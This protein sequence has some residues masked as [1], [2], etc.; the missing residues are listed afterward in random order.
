MLLRPFRALLAAAALGALSPLPAPAAASETILIKGGTLLTVTKGTIE[1]GDLLIRDGRIAAIGRD[2][3][4]P[5]GAR[6]IDATGRYVLPGIVDTHSHMGVYPWPEVPANDDGNEMTDPVTPGLRAA[7]SLWAED[8]EF[9]LARAGGV[10]TVQV[11]PGS[12]NLIGGEGVTLKLRPNAD[13]GRMIFAGAP[14]SIKMAL[15][16]N[17]KRVYGER[18]KAP[19][20]RMGNMALFRDAF[21]R[22]RNYRAK[23]QAWR[24]SKEKER[25]AP[26]D[27]DL[28]LDVL[29]DVLDGKVLV[30]VHSYRKDEILMFLKIADEYGFKVA[31]FQHGLEAYKIAPELA[32]RDIA[33]AT[34]AQWWGY[35]VEAWDG[36][37]HNAALLARAGV[38]V[39]IHSDSGNLVQRLYTEA[40]V[41]ARY[42]LAEEDALKAITLNAATA[43]GVGD[44]IGSLEV[45]KDADIAIF[46]RHPLDAYTLVEKTLIDGQVVYER[47]AIP[48][49]AGLP[50][51][52]PLPRGPSAPPPSELVPATA[53]VNPDGL[54]AVVG[55]RLFTMTG[56]PIDNGTLVVEKG[57]IKEVGAGVRPPE[58]ATVIDARGAWVF[59]GFIESHTSLGLAEIDQVDA[60][61][62]DDE[63]TDPITPDLRALDAYYTE[64]EIIPVTRLHGVTAAFA[65]PGEGNVLAGRGDVVRLEGGSPDEVLV[66]AGAALVAN[67]GEPPKARYGPRHESPETRMGIAALVRGAFTK[68]R[69]YQAKWVDYERRLKEFGQPRPAG[70]DARSG[71]APERPTPP[72]RDLKMEALLPALRGEMPVLVRAH[73]VDD[74]MTAVR[75]ASEFN[76]KLILSHGTE[77]YKVADLLAARNIPVVVGPITTQPE[78][79]ETAGAL[80]DNAA[81]LN[82]AGVKIAIQMGET[83]N[84][85]MLPYE[86]ALAVAY[87][88][89]WDQA[90]KAITI[91]PAEIL[92]VADRIGSLRPGLQADLIVSEGD[93][94]QPLARLR[95]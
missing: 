68:A 92:G 73:R 89:P 94:L 57:V 29:S 83:L 48:T 49:P 16:E 65:S 53:P 82:R 51:P 54:Y 32:R 21:N 46:T 2:L 36:I 62:D 13:V 35:K 55:G 7:D 61:R 67:L 22:A 20:T 9:A 95:H 8:P 37:P 33:V 74:I 91:N 27:R 41:A 1:K 10:T 93:P 19:S 15:G 76:L 12:G 4:S 84:G 5:P 3:G 14:R 40:A 30:H 31:S 56:P 47:G 87:G 80:Y 71:K 39:S 88:L 86:A 85:R 77:A 43:L 44:R 64:S 52:P 18:H 60:M 24:D 90:I 79:I 23:W 6:V 45:G 34:F 28:A 66:K 59:P 38:R 75:L 58:R 25:A 69:D 42:G 72:D 11:I 70:K 81:R 63:A 78:R 50:P 26:P 17:P